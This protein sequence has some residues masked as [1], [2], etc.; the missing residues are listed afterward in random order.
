VGGDSVKIWVLL[1]VGRV[2]WFEVYTSR[3]STVVRGEGARSGVGI[4]PWLKDV[5]GRDVMEMI[6]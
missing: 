4:D 2:G 5:V 1:R 6:S 3:H